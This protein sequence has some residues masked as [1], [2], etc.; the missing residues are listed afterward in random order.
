MKILFSLSVL[1]SSRVAALLVSREEY[2]THTLFKDSDETSTEHGCDD[3]CD[4]EV[5]LKD[6]IEIKFFGKKY[7]KFWPC[8]N[9][10]ISFNGEVPTFTPGKFPVA[11]QPMVA[12]FWADVDL[13][14]CDPNKG[15][16]SSR[17]SYHHVYYD[18]DAEF[19]NAQLTARYFNSTQDFKAKV[20]IVQSWDGVGYYERQKGKRNTFQIVIVSDGGS[21]SFAALSYGQ[22]E[23]TTGSASGGNDGLGGTPAQMGFDA[24]NKVNFEAHVNSRKDEIIEIANRDFFY[25][26]SELK[27]CPT[28]NKL[29]NDE[30]VP[31]SCTI[32][33]DEFPIHDTQ[34]LL[35]KTDQGADNPAY[36]KPLNV[37]EGDCA[38]FRA[39]EYVRDKVPS[40]ES[41][42]LKC[43]YRQD[44]VNKK[45]DTYQ[46]KNVGDVSEEAVTSKCINATWFDT[47]ATSCVEVGLDVAITGGFETVAVRESTQTTLQSITVKLKSKPYGKVYVLVYASCQDGVKP[48]VRDPPD[49]AE[50]DDKI[51]ECGNDKSKPLASIKSSGFKTFAQT[52]TFTST[53]WDTA[54]QVEFEGTDNERKSDKGYEN[55]KIYVQVDRS[56]ESNEENCDNRG[57]NTTK[58]YGDYKKIE[59]LDGILSD[60]EGLELISTTGSYE[61]DEN[62]KELVLSIDPGVKLDDDNTYAGQEVKCESSNKNEVAITHYRHGNDGEGGEKTAIVE[63]E[64]ITFTDSTLFFFVAGQ[65]DY[66]VDGDKL[67]QISCELKSKS[68]GS[69]LPVSVKNLDVNF[70]GIIVDTTQSG[71]FSESSSERCATDSVSKMV[72][73]CG[74]LYFGEKKGQ[75][76]F[77]VK[78][79]TKPIKNVVIEITTDKPNLVDISS[80]SATF[81]PTNWNDPQTITLKGIPDCESCLQAEGYTDAVVHILVDPFATEDAGS[82]SGVG[83]IYGYKDCVARVVAV[84]PKKKAT[85]T[86]TTTIPV[87]DGNGDRRR[88]LSDSGTEINCFSY[89]SALLTGKNDAQPD[90]SQLKLDVRIKDE[91]TISIPILV[92]SG[93]LSAAAIG[94]IIGGIFAVSALITFFGFLAAKKRRAEEINRKEDMKQKADQAATDIEFRVDAEMEDTGME[95]LETT[96]SKLL[97]ERD[98]LIEVNKKLAEEV[99]ESPMECATTEDQ[100]VL[101]EQIKSLK[102]EN[103]RLRDL[104]S[105]TAKRNPKKSKKKREGFGEQQA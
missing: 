53:D 56:S 64:Y 2:L 43:V 61:T 8:A 75:D 55:F 79:A 28:G 98:E 63:G 18:E 37:E 74:Y 45:Y 95:D 101:I 39:P 27:I 62:G 44:D 7:N 15:L 85:T 12:A 105:Q 13:R 94:G 69:M 90:E 32:S 48:V 14:T 52:L 103:D 78:L 99:G 50:T 41:C 26:I 76:T 71:N 54:Q 88:H 68:A 100:D 40:G 25:S 31:I 3:C 22:L 20:A 29:E 4:K 87:A 34:N 83:H 42:P 93:T 77:T 96:T 67:V 46:P 9:G 24:G 30:C 59:E 6:G 66:T 58:P 1:L 92:I 104:Q 89:T 57:C 10:L 84:D 33:A 86:T 23:W 35:S 81:T 82:G 11:D 47:A 38:K 73:G 65:P 102:G 5:L 21:N 72:D 19:L 91:S 16:R 97:G 36:K 80:K 51:Y 49:G 60:N 17:C 70:P